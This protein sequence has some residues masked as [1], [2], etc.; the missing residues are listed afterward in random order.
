MQ[1]I[2]GSDHRGKDICELIA[3][4]IIE[5]TDHELVRIEVDLDKVVDYP[6]VAAHAAREVAAGH[7]D[8]GILICGTGIG[9]CIVANKYPG[10]R[11]A[12]CHNEVVAEL[13]RRHNDA[14]ILCLSGDMLGER[15][16][17]AIVEKWLTTEFLGDRHSQRLDKIAHLES[18][19]A[20]PEQDA[21][22]PDSGIIT[23]ELSLS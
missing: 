15:A 6:D 21:N 11:A 13:S 7:A 3:D 1:I 14:N 5:K 18:G 10:V 19:H 17:L 22:G 20:L 16:T 12:P 8:R 9:V 4:Y 2:L 23:P